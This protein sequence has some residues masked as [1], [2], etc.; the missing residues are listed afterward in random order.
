M[1]NNQSAKLEILLVDNNFMDLHSLQQFLDKISFVKTVAIESKAFEA[2]IF[3]QEHQVDVLIMS[4]EMEDLDG[5]NLVKALSYTPEII[6]MSSN[7]KQAA[8]SYRCKV[9]YWL[10]KPVS[11]V[12]L[13]D[14]LEEIYQQ[15]L[16]VSHEIT[17]KFIT[18]NVR[19]IEDENLGIKRK[20]YMMFLVSEIAVFTS[21]GSVTRTVSLDN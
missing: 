19:R 8:I 14:A 13:K 18:I 17:Q 21:V 4:M 1:I 15:H 3:A 16:P 2:Y 11:F 9:K 7:E 6:F 10:Q 20:W 5:V 12:D